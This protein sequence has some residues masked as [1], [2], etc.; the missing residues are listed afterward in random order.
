MVSH[1]ILDTFS[2]AIGCHPLSGLVGLL[3]QK[4]LEPP[5]RPGIRM[6]IRLL[7]ISVLAFFIFLRPAFGESDPLDPA[8]L[9]RVKV[10]YA[11]GDWN[12]V[13]AL[14]STPDP[15]SPDLCFYRGMAFARLQ[16]WESALTFFRLG[17]KKAPRDTRFPAESAGIYFK[18][19]ERGK[20][21]RQL[22]KALAASPRDAYLNEFM[23]TIQQLSG[24]L[25]SALYY[26][27]R[28]GKPQIHAFSVDPPLPLNPLLLDRSLRFPP[29][30]LLELADLR[31]SAIRL[32]RLDQL[33]R[34]QFEL[35]PVPQDEMNLNL[36]AD[37]RSGWRENPGLNLLLTF[38][39]LPGQEVNLGF[40]N[41]GSSAWNSATQFRF[42]A[43]R[44][45]LY[46]SISGPVHKDPGKLLN[47]YL[48]GRREV[49]NFR[50]GSIPWPGADNFRLE[51]AKVGGE[52]RWLIRDHLD[53]KSGLEFAHRSFSDTPRDLPNAETL[54]GQGTSLKYQG[55][56]SGEL[57]S[58][59][60]R[61]FSLRSSFSQELARQWGESGMV[62]GR[63]QAG[64]RLEWFPRIEGKDYMVNARLRTGWIEGI[65]PF[66]EL[67]I[68][69]LERDSELWLRG[70]VGTHLGKK[71]NAPLGRNFLL[72]NSELDKRVFRRSLLE[73]WVAPFLDSGKFFDAMPSLHPPCWL[74]DAGLILRLRSPLGFGINISYGRDLQSG[75]DAFYVM[76]QRERKT[77]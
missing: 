42:H 24:N 74:W 50:A 7:L 72:A 54:F 31:A 30:G 10:L 76:F 36:R 15:G 16:Q 40:Y 61:R 65:V 35:S 39:A 21:I 60:V 49:W 63:T 37:H 70:H 19:Q 27:N 68:L 51:T 29:S 12:G 43:Q 34:P 32:A 13:L 77:D 56:L 57:F 9:E 17:A 4:T 44:R 45:R 64:L 66:D 14:T 75:H 3:R 23:G 5:F 62:Y 33:L 25:E 20:S 18:L 53:W 47:F 41:L 38:R 11:Q 8:F 28:I 55:S 73:I 46:S 6:E 67:Y 59:V 26:W 58:N 52:F 1:W 69:G 71:G 2:S 22:Q 48:D